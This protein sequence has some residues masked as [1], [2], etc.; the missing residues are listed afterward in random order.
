MSATAAQPRRGLTPAEVEAS[1]AAHGSNVLTPPERDPWWKLYLEKF[2]DPVIRILIIAAALAIGIGAVEGHVA[3]EGIGIV[4]A[5]FLAT[6]LA[7]W[8]EYRANREFDVLNQSNDDL[9]ITVTRDGRVTTIPRR[10]V[11]VGDIV[12]IETGEE[13][14]ADGTVVEAVGLQVSE[15]KMTGEARP[16]TKRPEGGDNGG[17]P[18]PANRADR[19][20]VVVDGYGVIEVTAVGDRTEYGKTLIDSIS[21]SN[22]N[23]TLNTQLAK[24][25]QIIGV[26]GFGIALLAFVALVGASVL[27]GALVLTFGQ[28]VVVAAGAVGVGIALIMVWAPVMYDGFELLGWNV[29]QPS[30]LG[31]DDDDDGDDEG[32][33]FLAAAKPWIVAAVLGAVVFGGGVAAGIGAGV[34]SDSPSEWMPRAAVQEFLRNFMIAVTIIVVAVPEGLAMSVTLS[35]AYSM[36][37]MT[38]SNT[39][40]RRMDACETIGAVTVVCSDKT[41]TLTRNEMRVFEAAVGAVSGSPAVPEGAVLRPLVLENLAANSTAHLARDPGEPVRPVGNP[42]EGALLLWLDGAGLDWAKARADF[43]I[44][45]QWTF[46][47]ERK[48]MGTLG[49]SPPLGRTVLHVKGAPEIVLARCDRFATSDGPRPMTDADRASLR[50]ALE[51]YQVRGMRT[52]AFAYRTDPGNAT[53]VEELAI[54]MVWLGFAAIADPVRDEVPP[55]IAVCDGAGVQVK[56][57]T[58]DNSETAR[59]I[60]RQIGLWKPDDTAAA[61]LTGAEFGALSDADAS[62][63]AAK[64]KVLSRARPADKL[65]LVQLLKEK[66][67]VVAVTGDGVNDGPALNHADVGLAMGK[68]GTAVAKEASD[69]V[70]LDDSFRSVTTAVLW[71]RALYENIQRFIL[72]QLTINVVAL[73]IAVLGPFIGFA[74]PLTVMQMLWVNL[75]MDTFAALALA[76]EPPHPGV[77]N[78][79]PRS[80]S[81]FIVTKRMAQVIFGVGGVFLAI[82]IGLIWWLGVGSAQDVEHATRGGTLLFTVFVMLQFWNLFNAKCMGRGGSVFASLFDNASF[83]GIAAAI[84]VGQILI[85]QFGGTAFR[86]VPLSLEDWLIITGATSAVLWIGEAVRLFGGKKG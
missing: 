64:L 11:V 41:G 61:H 18:I 48:M 10:E 60:A 16:V 75:I 29:P 17:S 69:I 2:N 72:F 28:W 68:T 6:F 78:R 12:H 37:K 56:I 74:L 22:K 8:N 30:W 27:S 33:S 80:P 44:A 1:R 86:T 65:R 38:A 55:A 71:G 31:G 39:L 21:D 43:A 40:V 7:F 36:R 84:L 85:V 32:K 5:I 14:S 57:V 53:S 9:P 76:T 34:V 62:T 66:G 24:L 52:L 83:L 51:G 15:A 63:A 81:D 35:L 73:G 3:V 25:S 67:E 26:V 13:V 70:L 59:E 82:L 49:Q 46:N 4:V 42:T 45:T 54:G 47:T 23:R 79:P 20:S 50:T 77:L 58:G 19:G